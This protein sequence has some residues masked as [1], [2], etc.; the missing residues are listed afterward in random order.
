M[1]DPSAEGLAVRPKSATG[2]RDPLVRISGVIREYKMGP[3][4][5]RALDSLDLEIDA[6]ELLAVVG[7][8]GSGKSTLL[9]LLGGLDTP[10]SGRVEVAGD[11]LSTTDLTDYRRRRVGIIFQSFHLVPSFTAL[12]N[13]MLALTFQGRTGRD[14][15]DAARAALARVGLAERMHH[16]PGQL[17]GGEQQRVAI[18][19]ATVHHPPLILADEP[20]G[21]LDRDS[22]ESVLTLLE[23]LR[24][25]GSTLVMVTHDEASARRHATRIVRLAAGRVE[26]EEHLAN[27]GV[28]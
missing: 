17:S 5:V 1:T 11:D 27:G 8:S 16:R 3:E 20:T 9:Q 2:D 24:S 25:E 28:A 23:E 14:R 18:A 7:V 13:V 26:T 19:R 4:T 15:K 22:A 12:E 21:N 6:G 10:S